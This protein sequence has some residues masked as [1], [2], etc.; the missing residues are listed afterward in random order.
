MAPKLDFAKYEIKMIEYDDETVK[1]KTL[2]DQA[3]IKGL[4][5]Y[6]FK[7]QPTIEI[8]LAII[9]PILW[10]AKNIISDENEELSCRKNILIDFI[11]KKVLRSEL[12][13]T[14]SNFGKILRHFNSCIQAHKLIIMNKTDMSSRN[15]NKYNDHLKSLITEDYLTVEHKGIKPKVIKDYTGFIVLSNMAYFKNLAKVLE[16]PNAPNEYHT[17]CKRNY[18]N[19]FTNKK[20]EKTSPTIGIDIEEFSDT[21]QSEISSNASTDISAFNFTNTSISPE[22]IDDKS[23][24][25]EIFPNSSVNNAV[26]NEPK[27]NKIDF[28]AF[29]DR[30]QTDMRICS[31]AKEAEEDSSEYM[32]ITVQ[33]RLKR[34]EKIVN[35]LQENAKLSNY[36][37]EL[38]K[39]LKDVKAYNHA[40]NWIQ[41][42]GFS[43][44]QTYALIPIQTSGKHITD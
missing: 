29:C 30:M 43:K 7:T 25:S 33:E 13:Y 19:P 27:T 24:Y 16:H 5:L 14:T 41:K 3:V 12:F 22:V 28:K 8:N 17:W 39:Y 36:A 1:L 38:V 32:D 35:I 37:E 20:F 23:K 2:I 10:H 44:N 4:I 42:L 18:K 31:F 21:P 26:N 6:R 40:Q 34:M 15:W 11:D 9:D